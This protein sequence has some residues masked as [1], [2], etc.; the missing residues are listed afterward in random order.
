MGRIGIK[1]HQV[2]SFLDYVEHDG[3][4]VVEGFF[5]HFASAWDDPAF[6]QDQLKV[7]EGAVAPYRGIKQVHISNSAAI[8]KQI[9]TDYDFVRPGQALTVSHL[10][11]VVLSGF[12]RSTLAKC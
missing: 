2:D 9:G 10:C 7:F 4:M 5:S 1:P 6:T 3:R 8:I 12:T 11:T